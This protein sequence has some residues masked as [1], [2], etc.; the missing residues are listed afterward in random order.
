MT[1]PLHARQQSIEALGAALVAADAYGGW[2]GPAQR[3]KGAPIRIMDNRRKRAFN[4]GTYA[5]LSGA[6]LHRLRGIL[7]AGGTVFFSRA[8]NA[9]EKALFRKGALHETPEG[10]VYVT[11]KGVQ[12]YDEAAFTARSK[13]GAGYFGVDYETTHAQVPPGLFA[14]A[15]R[16]S[17]PAYAQMAT[18]MLYAADAAIRT[19]GIP[20]TI[21]P[22]AI[23][24]AAKVVDAPIAAKLRE[25]ADS[26][27]DGRPSADDLWFY[28]QAYSARRAGQERAA[29]RQRG[30]K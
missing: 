25:V 27:P 3:Q 19:H 5:G 26:M 1:Q 30:R 24:E 21:I 7:S 4:K 2:G 16:T 9:T 10:S 6:Q 11:R 15:A 12:L 28:Q 17:S 14:V 22:Y 18:T 20:A 13:G 23:R 29:R 8:F